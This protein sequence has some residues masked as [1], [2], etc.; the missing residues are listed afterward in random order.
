MAAA[1]EARG[2]HPLAK[3]LAEE[4]KSR[5]VT[6][7][8][9]ATTEV[10]L[11]LGVRATWDSD[12]VLVGNRAFMESEGVDVTYFKGRAHRCMESGQTVLYVARNG[13]LQGMIAVANAV[14]HGVEDVLRD[15]R[16]EGVSRMYLISGDVRPIVEA[17]SESLGFDGY[18]APLLPQDKAEYIDSLEASGRRVVMVGD[19]VNDALA[20]SKA[21]V[22]IAMGAGG[23]EAAV[24]AADIALAR[25]ELGDLM[26]LRLL[27]H[28]TLRTIDQN[29]WMANLTNILGILLGASGWFSPVMAGTLHVA[30]TLGIMLNSSRLLWWELP[31]CTSTRTN[32]IQ[33]R[34]QSQR[35]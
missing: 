25:S 32:D 5:G 1:A 22:G 23:A 13:R 30:H 35:D 12:T 27:S 26:I 34:P 33:V 18:E 14:R 29:F 2:V 3:A 4:A 31:D 8:Q 17:I 20:L 10:F 28:R 7:T 9:D 16:K 21:S 24:E 11:G 19:G 6:P 15:L